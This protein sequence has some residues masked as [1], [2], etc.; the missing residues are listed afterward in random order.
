[1][2]VDARFRIRLDELRARIAADRAAGWRPICAIGNAGTVN[3]G[4]VDDLEGLA[5]LCAQER[6]WFHVDG[7]LGGLAA[8]S[9]ALRPQL[10]GLERADSLGF[11]LHKWG[12]LQYEIGGLLVRD[13]RAHRAAFAAQADYLRADG[14]GI[15]KQPLEFA[16]LGLGLSRGFRALRA[17]LAFKAHGV[18][19]IGALIE[20]NV[21]QVARLAARVE[22][23][24][25]LELLAPPSLN[26]AC[27]RYVRPG[28]DEP[29]LER[30]NREL[31]FRLQEDG[32]A[33]PS[34]TRVRGRFAL[35]VANANHRTRDADFEALVEAAVE[36]GD[37]LGAP[38]A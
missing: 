19:A 35:R 22:A 15:L 18:D 36:R 23:H 9:P 12:Y 6:L 14:R 34:S 29:A 31:L 25:R 38:A 27:F 2:D 3:T 32:V 30:L 21:A 7:C 5:E 33:V 1:V 17:W 4:A 28:L 26:V 11:D 8:L 16:A 24:P 37:A 13:A 20:Q 10:R